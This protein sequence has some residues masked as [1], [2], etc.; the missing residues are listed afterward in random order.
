MKQHVPV[1]W[2]TSILFTG[3]SLVVQLVWG[4]H[5]YLSA[6]SSICSYFGL[7]PGVIG[8]Q[9]GP[10]GTDYGQYGL[11]KVGRLLQAKYNLTRV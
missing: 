8:W 6:L 10:S 7:D 5:F 4:K 9:Y 2:E 11:G 1:L 3:S